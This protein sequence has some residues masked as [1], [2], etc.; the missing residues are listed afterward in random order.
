[1]KLLENAVFESL[2]NTLLV[3]ARAMRIDG[4]IESYSCK[5]AGN[6]KKLYKMLNQEGQS[7]SDLQALSPPQTGQPSSISPK[8]SMYYGSYENEMADACSRKML[9]YLISTL[10][11]S[12]QP[13]YDFSNAKS[14]EFSR[15]PNLQL[16]IDAIDSGL[17]GVLE[18]SYCQ[19]KHKL[20][21][22]IEAEIQ[23]ADCIVYSYNPDLNSDPYGEE[24]C[25][26][27]FNYFFYNK[28]MKRI[29][30]FTCRGM[31]LSAHDPMNE[32]DEELEFEMDPLVE[33]DYSQDTER[34]TPM[35]VA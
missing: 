32:S 24:G 14:E 33:S 8:R 9:F 22:A 15:E 1:M 30:F 28:K 6:D 35:M 17:S 13:D 31:C 4:R 34:L 18:E 23:L 27:S 29:V 7:P 19:F 20:W 11:A 16:V 5:M 26:W 10:N 3:Q 12:F 21:N 2:T 25:L